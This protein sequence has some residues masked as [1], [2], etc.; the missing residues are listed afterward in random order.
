MQIEIPKTIRRL[1]QI[2]IE[3]LYSKLSETHDVDLINFKRQYPKILFPGKT[4]IES[5]SS[6]FI[7]LL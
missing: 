2:Y 7:L 4:Q 3:E 5:N 1:K 6:I